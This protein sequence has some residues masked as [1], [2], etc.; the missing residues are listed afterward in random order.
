M[1]PRTDRRRFVAGLTSLAAAAACGPELRPE[2]ELAMPSPSPAAR[3][4]PVLFVGH[5]SPMNAIEDNPWSRAFRALGRTL[6][7]PAG[8]LS[9]SAHWYGHGSHVTIQERPET[10]HDFGGF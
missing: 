5:G 3:R 6:A 4:H 2:Q 10:L 7:K 8:V 1:D 9:V